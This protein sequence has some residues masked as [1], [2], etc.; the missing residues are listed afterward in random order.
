MMWI[1]VIVVGI[2]FS[3]VAW[4][5]GRR[6]VA[7]HFAAELEKRVTILEEQNASERLAAVESEQRLVRNKLESV[8]AASPRKWGA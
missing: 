1:S 4:D 3:A 6:L 7:A 5:L 8:R 2:V